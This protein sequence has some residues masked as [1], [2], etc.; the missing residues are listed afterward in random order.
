M[1]A[2]HFA[3]I[4][5]ADIMPVYGALIT[6]KGNHLTVRCN[7][8]REEYHLRCF[9][10][11]WVG[12]VQ[13]CSAGNAV[14]TCDSTTIRLRSDNDASRAPASIRREQKMNMS[15]GGLIA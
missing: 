2:F 5:C 1:H 7:Q 15:M 10:M 6:R 4:G 14:I 3:V 11:K 13:N 12:N 8:S 9:N